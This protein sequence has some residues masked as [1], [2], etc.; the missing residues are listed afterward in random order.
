VVARVTGNGPVTL[1]FDYSW[2]NNNSQNV[3]QVV[4]QDVNAGSNEILVD[5]QNVLKSDQFKLLK[6]GSNVVVRVSADGAPRPLQKQI[7][8]FCVSP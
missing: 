3:T 4:T 5:F 7:G 6:P 1:K 8:V 2:M